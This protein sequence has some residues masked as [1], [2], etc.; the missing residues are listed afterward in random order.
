MNVRDATHLLPNDQ[1][2]G[3][4]REGRPFQSCDV[5]TKC[6]PEPGCRYR[7]TISSGFRLEHTSTK[8]RACDGA[9]NTRPAIRAGVCV[10]WV[11]PLVSGRELK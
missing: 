8:R 5:N 6:R 7:I 11:C 1:T 2:K 10:V 9:P 3:A 4:T